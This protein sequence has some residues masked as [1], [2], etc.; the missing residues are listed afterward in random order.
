MS[1]TNTNATTGI[2]DKKIQQKLMLIAKQGQYEQGVLNGESIYI[3]ESKDGDGPSVILLREKKGD[4]RSPYSME[5]LSN[6]G[7]TDRVAP[8]M[9]RLHGMF[10]VEHTGT[11]RKLQLVEKDVIVCEDEYHVSLGGM[12]VE[13]AYVINE[14]L[15]QVILAHHE[16]QLAKLRA[17]YDASGGSLMVILNANQMVVTWLTQHISNMDKKIGQFAKNN[18]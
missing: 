4:P 5:Y 2:V 11:G 10:K 17:D 18:H 16:Q 8:E 13:E 7:L 9:R 3:G 15:Y 12:P 14:D 1:N 6:S